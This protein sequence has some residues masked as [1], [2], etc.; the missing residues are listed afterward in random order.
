MPGFAQFELVELVHDDVAN[1]W[2]AREP[3]SGRLLLLHKFSRAS[4]LREKIRAMNPPDM[5]ALIKFGEESG[6][7]YAVTHDTPELRQ[8]RRWVESRSKVK[9]ASIYPPSVNHSDPAKTGLWRPPA[10]ATPAEPGTFTAMFGAPEKPPAT[11]EPAPGAGADHEP[12][13]QPGEFTRMFQTPAPPPKPAPLP[14]EPAPQ[15]PAPGE[16]TRMFQAPSAE[17]Q[18]PATLSPENTPT[19]EIPAF[20][21]TPAPAEPP[22]TP[23]EF[24]RM[25]QQPAATQPDSPA[26]G[27][28]REPGELTRMFNSSGPAKS[29]PFS[30]A[31]PS[32]P[33]AFTRMFQEQSGNSAGPAPTAPP[34]P[35]GGAQPG[36]F[37]R[38]FDTA[39]PATQ[40]EENSGAAIAPEPAP[41][42][43][44]N[45][46]RVFGTAESSG[47]PEPKASA[48]TG[49]FVSRQQPAPPAA[50]PASGPAGE[51]TRLF[52]APPPPA[53]DSAVPPPSPAPTASSPVSS[54][55]PSIKP[56]V[57]APAAVAAV[58]A[59]KNYIAL[60]VVL[61]VLA[62]VA[63]A[64][65]LY[66]V[67]RR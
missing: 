22:A 5:G 9:S 47:I 2:L 33:G 46:T 10:A 8:F 30:K 29:E 45:F 1:T 66:F 18:R 20:V 28:Q 21:E 62:V 23:G 32:D 7:F 44:G 34:Q 36:N 17:T 57:K 25:F 42:D 65:I 61:A 26:P 43:P 31:P 63:I 35:I 24:T 49:A 60:V 4:G 53:Q 6:L 55:A 41:R 15:K 3:G 14:Q 64:L 52:S 13:S 11:K 51:F 54:P 67:L 12:P 37:T 40:H 58:A 59:P 48:A 38:I 19:M 16:F 39:M 56:E 50:P 27:N